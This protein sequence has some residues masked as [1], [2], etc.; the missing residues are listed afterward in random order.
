MLSTVLVAFDFY[1]DTA[2]YRQKIFTS[3]LVFFAE[4]CEQ[5]ETVQ[6]LYVESGQRQRSFVVSHVELG[7]F[8]VVFEDLVKATFKTSLRLSV[9]LP[10]PLLF[11][12]FYQF[13]PDIVPDCIREVRIVREGRAS[14]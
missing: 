8:A 9:G 11:D 1:E 13:W 12:E 14:R 5:D 10:F 4:R 6:N 3:D 2:F 7:V